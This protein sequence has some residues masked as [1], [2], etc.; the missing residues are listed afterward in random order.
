MSKARAPLRFF[1]AN[2]LIGRP[3]IGTPRRVF[4]P[5]DV[6]AAMRRLGIVDALIVHN[7]AVEHDPTLGNRRCLRERGGR[8][9]FW[10]SAVVLP[11]H[12]GSMPHPRALV[13]RLLRRG[14]RAVR[15]YPKRH[16]F[17]M[18]ELTCGPMFDALQQWRLPLV[19]DMAESDWPGVQQLASARPEL[20]LVIANTGYGIQR[21]LY[22]LFETCP[23]VYFEI[24][25]CHGH[26]FLED[27]TRRFGAGRIL[28]GSRLPVLDAGP[29]VAMV[30]YAD[31]D[32]SDKRLIAR[33]NLR[34]LLA[35]VEVPE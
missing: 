14:V 10:P 5:D 33:D 30:T 17:T 7:T 28:F 24:S 34:R 1:D 29:A 19:L 16:G 13:P 22:P 2:V 23:H 11:H 18:D 20:R 15:L 31:L 9:A 35:E 8:P 27:V 6:R 32:E 21:R 26:G 3:R 12:A 25:Q 4:E